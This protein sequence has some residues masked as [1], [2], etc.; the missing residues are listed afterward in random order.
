MYRVALCEDAQDE[1]EDLCR[2]LRQA[3]GELGAEAQV[4]AYP[5]AEAL[6]QALAGGQWF[7]LFVLDILLE[8][9]NGMDLA[10]EL[11]R[12]DS[13]VGILF[14]TGSED[15]LREGYAVRPLH[16]L[17]KPVD[18]GALREA[19][20]AGLYQRPAGGERLT[21]R[22]SG[23]TVTFPLKDILYL[24]SRNHSVLVCTREGEQAF[25][26]S[27][28]SLER[29][30]PAKSFCRCHNS[31]VVN[32]GHVAQIGRQELLLDTGG[33]LAVSRGFYQQLQSR[34]IRYLNE[35]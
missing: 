6:E 26:S 34:L 14:I 15:F 22:A 17:F 18:P 13:Q 19:L 32:L 7:D 24:E 4:D 31:F 3:L 5:S 35:K 8:G 29:L 20:E 30:L 27:L 33:R 9:K 21:F 12:Q 23:R 16:Y 25:R 28:A 10:L 11:R 2:L 1:R